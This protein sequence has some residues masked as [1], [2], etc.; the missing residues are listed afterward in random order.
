MKKL[1]SFQ[2]EPEKIYQGELTFRHYRQ[3]LE[4]HF[5]LTKN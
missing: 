5:Y 1:K 4:M 3:V 2:I